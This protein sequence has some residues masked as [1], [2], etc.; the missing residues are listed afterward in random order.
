[1]NVS[2][3]LSFRLRRRIKNNI[4]KIAS[5]GVILD[6]RLERLT[7]IFDLEVTPIL[8]IKLRV[9]WPG[10]EDQ[11]VFQDGDSGSHLGIQ[12]ETI[13]AIFWSTSRPDISYQVL[14]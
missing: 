12:I 9:S 14:S 7:A 6:F 4:F 2:S 10:K 3:Q 1:M 13:L 11:N 5:L 8:P